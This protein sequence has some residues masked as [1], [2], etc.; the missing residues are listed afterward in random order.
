MLPSQTK[1]TLTTHPDDPIHIRSRRLLDVDSAC[2]KGPGSA[3]RS[4]A[5]RIE[6]G[7]VCKGEEAEPIYS[8]D[9]RR[10]NPWN[11][12]SY[13]SLKQERLPG[14]ERQCRR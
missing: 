12:V 13:T 8:T 1:P 7:N 3:S 6:R 9:A 5:V 2:T 11:F 10:V 14:P 4:C